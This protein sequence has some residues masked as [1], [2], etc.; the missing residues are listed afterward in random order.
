MM[1][2][3][4]LTKLQPKELRGRAREVLVNRFL[5]PFLPESLDL[6]KGVVTSV[7]GAKSGEA[8]VIIYDKSAYNFFKPFTFYMPEESKLFPSE[9]VY[10]VI[11]VE[12]NLTPARLEACIERIRHVKNLPKTAYYEQLGPIRHVVTLYGK[13]WDYYP[14]LGAIFSF[15][16]GGLGE[17]RSLLEE[18]NKQ[19]NLS[20]E[21]QVDLICVLKKGMILHSET[22]KK[23]IHF[24]PIPECELKYRED[25]P[26]DNLRLFYLLLMRILT[27]AWTKPIKVLDYHK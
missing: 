6:G 23:L 27:Q 22:N 8:D 17:L 16:S 12:R 5:K 4:E 26:A 9:V 24:P 14:I 21:H 13:E 2:E 10:V 18:R 7:G 3:L 20:I 19:Y 11:E 1:G 15:D 25:K